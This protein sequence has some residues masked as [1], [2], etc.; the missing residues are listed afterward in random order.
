MDAEWLADSAAVAEARE[1][2]RAVVALE[3][4]VIAQGL[5]WPENLETARGMEEAVRSAGAVP[6][7]IAVVG[8]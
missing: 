2:G 6:A 5:P 3:T 8:G 1:Q 4:T 7:T